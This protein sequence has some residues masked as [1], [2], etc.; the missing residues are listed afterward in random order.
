[1]GRDLDYFDRSF[2]GTDDKESARDFLQ[3]VED[4]LT[5]KANERAE[6]RDRLDAFASLTRPKRRKTNSRDKG[7]LDECLQMC[8]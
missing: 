8:S 1:M 2:S 5:R 3:S 7:E 6:T 4:F